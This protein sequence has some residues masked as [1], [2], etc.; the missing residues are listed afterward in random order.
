M[1]DFVKKFETFLRK[2]LQFY[3]KTD[4]IYRRF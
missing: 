3:G 4:I 2:R 1:F